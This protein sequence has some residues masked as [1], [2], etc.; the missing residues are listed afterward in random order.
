MNIVT[1]CFFL[2]ECHGLKYHTG[3]ISSAY[4][5]RITRKRILT[6]VGPV[7][8]RLKGGIMIIHESHCGTKIVRSRRHEVLSANLRDKGF[9]SSKADTDL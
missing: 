6:I 3:D 2:G 4:L 8:A 5:C 1:I 7:F 9:I